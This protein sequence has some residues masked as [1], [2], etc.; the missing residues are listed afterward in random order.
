MDF[1]RRTWAEI[2]LDAISLNFKTLR[3]NINKGTKIMCIVK[4]DGYGHGAEHVS[5]QLQQAGTD[6][7]GVSN[8]EEALQLRKNSIEKPILILGYT[9]PEFAKLLRDYNLTQ[10]VFSLEYAKQ[11]SQSAQKNE[12]SVDIHIKLDTGMGRIG[13]PVNNN[14]IETINTILSICSMKGITA[15]GIYTHFARADEGKNDNQTTK[16]QFSLFTNT[17]EALQKAGVHFELRHCCNS[18]ATLNYPEMHLDM[19][20]PGIILYGLYPS[21]LNCQSINLAPAMELKSVISM[22]KDIEPDCSIGYGHR[23]TARRKTKV[24]T[25]PIGYADGYS[26]AMS[27]RASMLINGK[28][29]PVIGTVSMDQCMI[30]VTDI[31]NI[32]PGMTVTVIGKDANEQITVDDISN[33]AGTINY[34]TVCL[35]GK[36]VPRIYIKDGSVV[37]Q[38][39][40]FNK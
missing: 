39:N 16:N 21:S 37:A 28:K 10:T 35:I 11:L 3:Q 22:L 25:L 2:N 18:A 17:L 23:F 8:I 7:F 29:T 6:W 1:L 14:I 4:A 13:I 32:A 31:D 36:R 19:V 15:K 9:P 34:E 33:I 30:D 12:V 27:S 5:T 38:L 24:A 26:R 40:Y 20:R